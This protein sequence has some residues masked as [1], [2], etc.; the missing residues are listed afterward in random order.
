M[1]AFCILDDKARV[2]SPNEGLRVA[3]AL[4]NEALDGCLH[5]DPRS[6]HTVS[7]PAFYELGEEAFDGVAA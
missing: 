6:E 4:G 1:P 7:E 5:L 3:V 2:G